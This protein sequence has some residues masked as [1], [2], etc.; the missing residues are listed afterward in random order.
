MSE[1]AINNLKWIIAGAAAYQDIARYVADGQ[2]VCAEGVSGGGKAFFIASLLADPSQ[3]ALVLTFNEERATQLAGDLKALL[4]G[5]GARE[6]TRAGGTPAPRDTP[7]AHGQRRV[8]VY[9]SLA[10]ALYDGVTPER[11]TVAERLTVLER[12]CSG[13][14]VIVVAAIRALTT[15]TIPS[16]DLVAARRDVA[17]GEEIDRDDLARALY[18]LGY[19]S[20]DLVDEVGQFSVR[21]GIVDVSPPTSTLPVRIELLGDEV[22]TIR[23]FD[24]L[25]QRSLDSLKTI[26]F[27]PAGEILLTEKAVNR[28]LPIIKGAFRRELDRL[29]EE[30]KPREAGL[31]KDR[32]SEDLELLEQLRPVPGLVHYLPYIYPE[33]E[34]LC[35]Y[36]PGEAIFFVDEP[37][38]VQ[39]GAEQFEQDV[40]DAY[41]RGI[42]LG[43]HLRLPE[44]AVMHFDKLAALHLT[45]GRAIVHLSM[46]QRQVPWAQKTPLV[47]LATPPV[48]SF[49]GRFEM[50]AE[51]LAEWQQEGQHLLICSRDVGGTVEVLQSRGLS[52]VVARTAPELVAGQITVSPLD[53]DSGFRLPESKLVLLT[54][55][56]IF[57]WRKLRRPEE[58]AFTRGFH[59]LSLRDLNEGD[60]VVHI[61]HGVAIYKG[62]SRQTVGGIE[63]DYM[64]L[65]YADNDKLY[66]PVTQLD[67]VQKYI[68]AEQAR[69]AVT[70][71]K[72][73]RWEV[74]KKKAKRSAQLLARELMRLYSARAMAKGHAFQPDSPWLKELEASFRFEETPDQ[75][76][77]IED[78][79]GDME[80]SEPADRLICGDV[81][82]GKTEVAIRAAFKAVLDGKQVAVLVPTTVLAQQHYNTFRERLSR[83]P[84]EVAVLSRFKSAAE[85]RRLVGCLK[86]GT[87]DVVIGTHRLL[88]EDVQF[89][90]LGLLI[91]DEEQR[92][93]VRQKEKLKRFRE[94]VDVVTLTA[95]PIPRTLNMAL[96]G[97][98]E[99]SI[100]NDPPQGRLAIHTEVRERDEALIAEVI[101]RE[102]ARGGQVYF[103]HNRVHSIGHVAALVQRLVPEA[104]V[105]VAHGQMEEQDLERVMMAFYAEDF[106]VLVC[107]TIIENGLD[108]PNVNTIIVDEADRLGLSQLYQLR[109]RVGRSSRQAYAYLLYRYPDRM[110]QEAEER[111]KAIE[112]FSK[113]GS[114]FQIALRDLEIRGAGDILGAEQSGHMSAVGLDLYTQMLADAVKTLKGEKTRPG[115]G[116][117]TVDLPL[118]AIIPADY[119]PNENQ[120]ISLYR[121]LAAVDELAQLRAIIREFKDRF[122]PL[123][124][125]VKNLGRIV[126]LKLLAMEVGVADIAIADGRVVV[127]VAEE[128]ALSEREQRM[129]RGLYVPTIRQQR[130]GM[131]PALPRF[132]SGAREISFG[133]R[134]NEKGEL[135]K[136]LTELLGRLKDRAEAGATGKPAAGARLSRAAKG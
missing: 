129:L 16:A 61:N 81:G 20:V 49:G 127:T 87:V 86:A 54:G 23:H 89:H 82:Y 71:L 91:I 130:A 32:I 5:E 39:S 122:G 68:G 4:E 123:P 1:A 40:H 125:P 44:T 12:L 104:R 135:L 96:S 126:Q 47:H 128:A 56:E 2:Q 85:Q 110:T 102:L 36:F 29:N 105:A 19:E 72:G 31:L 118:E 63:R 95:T 52:N 65:Q 67:R 66:V 22:E 24:P 101:R 117:P 11:A 94:G 124:A 14:P 21:G 73:G 3:S 131:K 42:R 136:R 34:S 111:L 98:R 88:G 113:L 116:H 83:Y 37:V 9:P 112:E 8:L 84:V 57:G 119:V 92:F 53:L 58:P 133:Y 97:I 17:V 25:T 51:G 69:P 75:L 45:K 74:A 100:I 18:N 109:G 80:K 114:G 55:R 7:A 108:I 46:L 70:S 27:G 62:L 134:P 26:G 106:D 120:R 77:A 15:M 93:G 33:A 28:A 35:S 115:E 10:S 13:E 60:Y 41:R 76:R 6:D 64:L 50:L 43:Q 132:L 79:K 99:I 90:D 30:E 107:T 48:D 103:V 121:R 78:V 38:R 59:L